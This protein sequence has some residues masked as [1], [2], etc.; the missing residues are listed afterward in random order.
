MIADKN[1]IS[2]R[3]SIHSILDKLSISKE[4]LEKVEKNGLLSIE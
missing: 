2:S 1:T 3:Q 4:F